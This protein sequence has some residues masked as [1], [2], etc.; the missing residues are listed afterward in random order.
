MNYL[1]L[2]LTL[3]SC[4]V[5]QK[6]LPSLANTRWEYKI[7]EGCINSYDFKSD[8]TFLYYSCEQEDSLFGNYFFK[9]DTL[10]ID[11]KGSIYDKAYKKDSPH[12]YERKRYAAIISD[13]QMKHL[14]FE[15]II[16]RDWKKSDFKLSQENLYKKVEK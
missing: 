1:I 14:Y 3:L 10:F 7:A 16:N 9:N 5:Q 15:E 8:S 2:L 6:K 12:R 13:N 4:N 11:K